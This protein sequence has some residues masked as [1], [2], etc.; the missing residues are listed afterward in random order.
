MQYAW[1]EG[2]P[3]WNAPVPL[4]VEG[5]LP[6]TAI[7]CLTASSWYTDD[8]RMEVG[9]QM[10]RCYFQGPAGHLKEIQYSGNTWQYLGLV[11]LGQ[12]D[13]SVTGG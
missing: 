9:D 13:D 12:G 5:S 10:S 3:G 7:T 11:H 1:L 8:L 6:G 4:P 2:G